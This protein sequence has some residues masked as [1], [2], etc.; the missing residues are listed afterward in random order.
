M[1]ERFQLTFNSE[2]F[3]SAVNKPSTL[4]LLA[5]IIELIY[6][7][8]LL[9]LGE[10]ARVTI[11]DNLDIVIPLN[12]MLVDS[13]MMFAASNTIVPNVMGGLPRFLFG[14]EL[15]V[16]AW[17]FILFKPFTAYLINEVLMH[18]VALVSMIV[19]LRHYFVPADTEGRH[20]II[21]TAAILFSLVHFYVGAGLSV[22]LLPL[23]LYAFLNIRE[24]DTRLHNWLIV[25]LTPFYSNLVLVYFFFLLVMGIFF[26]IDWI[27]IR[28]FNVLFLSALALMSVF[29][30]IVEHH[31]VYAMFFAE[32]FVSHR[33]EFDLSQ[34]NS[35]LESYR[36]A[37]EVLL[38]GLK[39]M[40]WRLSSYGMPFL[41]F[42]MVLGMLQ[43]R[44]GLR[45]SIVL[46]ASFSISMLFPHGWQYVTGNKWTLPV[47]LFTSIFIFWKHPKERCFYG[48]IILLVLASYWYGFWFY[49]GVNALAEYL[50]ILK[51]FNF[52]RIAFLLPLL[53][54]LLIALGSIIIMKRLQWGGI[55]L[56]VLLLF[57]MNIMLNTRHFDFPKDALSFKSYFAET[58]FDEIDYYIGKPKN[59][60]RIGSLTIEPSVAIY[61]G[62]YTI[63]GYMPN[64]PLTYKK[65]FYKVIE[66]SL[67]KSDVYDNELFIKWGSKC[68]LF[69]G[70]MLPLLYIKNEVVTQ[71]DLD[72]KAYRELGGEYLISSHEINASA[73]GEELKFLKRFDSN[74][75]YWS[76]YLYAVDV[77]ASEN[78]DG[79]TK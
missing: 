71:L 64:Y 57:Q 78:R 1:I 28:K 41:L 67:Q 63:D 77:N 53:W 72:Y 43:H 17:L 34:K 33:V 59:T 27:R 60:Y 76:L 70:G 37:H 44:L 75:T 42:A 58:L 13:G 46:I 18:S 54:Y 2:E 23:A 48:G 61:N 69:D 8:P 45:W 47:M 49:E 15:N 40:D 66:K 35:L 9:F 62:F 50:P 22:P 36:V 56:V 51:Q 39:N 4:W 5:I 30:L 20:L 24:G 11:Y 65:R 26:I 6:L 14:S 68:Y 12:K 32:G 73:L 21:F 79:K 74:E 52:A 7:F 19:L 25:V 10:N 31:L 38:N 55:L 29:F 3:L 16:F